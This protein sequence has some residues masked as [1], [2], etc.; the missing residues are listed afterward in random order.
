MVQGRDR[1]RFIFE[2]AQT[3]RVIGHRRWE[4][5]DGDVTIETRI[6][7]AVDFAHPARAEQRDD[8]VRAKARTGRQSQGLG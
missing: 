2:S 8:F 3:I 5:F 7:A 4:N 6:A 1:P